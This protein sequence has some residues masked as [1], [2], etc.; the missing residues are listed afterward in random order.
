[1]K[2]V[3]W[4]LDKLTL[5]FLREQTKEIGKNKKDEF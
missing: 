1:M 4:L 5:E 2:F 3:L